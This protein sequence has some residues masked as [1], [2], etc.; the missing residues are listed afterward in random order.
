MEYVMNF[1]AKLFSLW[2]ALSLSFGSAV[3]IDYRD[4][5]RQAAELGN[6]ILAGKSFVK[7]PFSHPEK[8]I[9]TL[10]TRTTCAWK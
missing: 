9:Y 1:S 4:F 5:D 8:I 6:S 3:S 7:T 10:N 2:V